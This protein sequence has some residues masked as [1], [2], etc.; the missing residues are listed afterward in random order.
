MIDRPG[1][2]R[3][4]ILEQRSTQSNINELNAAADPQDGQLSLPRNREQS[5]LE[6][7]TLP[8]GRAQ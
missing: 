4:E 5:E 7:V 3:R 2:L 8:A 1:A 6:K